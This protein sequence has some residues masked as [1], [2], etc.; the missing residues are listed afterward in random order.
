MAPE[1]SGLYRTHVEADADLDSLTIGHVVPR[2]A[3]IAA[4]TLDGERV[5]TYETRV[6]N[7]GMEISVNANPE[8]NQTLVVRTRS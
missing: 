4:V 1:D 2:T 3:E 8:A 5:E 6:T 7:R